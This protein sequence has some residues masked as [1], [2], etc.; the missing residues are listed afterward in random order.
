MLH[1]ETVPWFVCG[2]E[3]QFVI[4]T[5][6]SREVHSWSWSWEC[7]RDLTTSSLG[8]KRHCWS[9]RWKNES[10]RQT[11]TSRLAAHVC[12]VQR[13]TGYSESRCLLIFRR[14]EL[15]HFSMT[16][17]RPLTCESFDLVPH[18][19][20]SEAFLSLKAQPVTEIP[21][22]LSHNHLAH[23]VGRRSSPRRATRELYLYQIPRRAKG[24]FTCPHSP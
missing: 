2:M 24:S 12:L 20:L 5:A 11:P 17:F 9:V 16:A 3:H 14:P 1:P 21:Y 8:T 6:E 18:L 4:L 23:E 19:A 7:H 22:G 13:T 10:H 15:K